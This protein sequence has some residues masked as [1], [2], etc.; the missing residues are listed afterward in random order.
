MKR[1]SKIFALLAA[2][3]LV[4]AAAY[5]SYA[6]PPRQSTR[7]TKKRTANPPPAQ[8]RTANPPTQK[9]GTNPPP[10][11]RTYSSVPIPPPQPAGFEW[12]SPRN[13]DSHYGDHGKEFPGFT[14]EH[15]SAHA[16]VVMTDPRTDT[17]TH[18]DG[19][20]SYH[21][22]ASGTYLRTNAAGKPVTMFRPEFPKNYYNRQIRKDGGQ[23]SQSSVVGGTNSQNPTNGQMQGSTSTGGS[24][25][26]N[27]TNGQ[28]QG[29]SSGVTNSQNSSTSQGKQGGGP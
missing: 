10:T 9:S 2:T 21:H 29:S 16:A 28:M 26:Q 20:R 27:P 19:G 6:A 13:L 3:A 8:K 17:W 22:G 18:Q 24:Q 15:Y 12:T 5:P 23:P 14:K 11:Q 4:T 1:L 7:T 25:G